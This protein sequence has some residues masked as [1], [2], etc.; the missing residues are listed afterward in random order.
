MFVR[1]LGTLEVSDG[2]PGS[3]S[4]PRAVPGAKERALLGRLLICPGRAVPVN[5]LIDD[6]WG[7]APP[8]SARKSLQAHVVRLRTSLEPERPRG[9]PGQ[10]VVHRGDG[11]LLAFSPKEVDAGLVGLSAASGRAALAA[12]QAPAA[13]TLFADALAYW[14]GEAFADWPDAP[15]AEGERR[16]LAGIREGLLEG[17]IDAD[18]ALGRHREL[19]PELEAMAAAEP[20]NEGWWRRLMLALYRSERQADALAAGR[21]ARARLDREL[22]VQP[23]PQLRQLEEEILR[24]SATLEPTAAARS[25]GAGTVAAGVVPASVAAETVAAGGVAASPEVSN[26]APADT[27]P[28]RGL[29]R[30]EA[31][32]ARL[33]FGRGPVIRGLVARVRSARLVVVSGPSGAGKSSLVRAG[34]LPELSRDVIP[35]SGSWRQMVITPGE[36]PV[37]RLAAAELTGDA[38]EPTVLV[39]DQFEELWTGPVSDGEREAFLAGLL[40]LLD[41]GPV[42]R[43]VLVVRGDHL[44]RLADMAELADATSSGLVLAPPMTE[45]E[46]REVVQGPAAVASLLVDPDLTETV[47]REV[48]GRAGVLPLLSSAL[49]GTWERRRGRSLTLSGYLECGGVTGALASVA[50]EAL[51]TLG[52]AEQDLAHR[53]LVRLAVPGDAGTVVRRSAPL[54]ELGVLPGQ[55]TD[56]SRTLEAFVAARLVTVDNDR[57]EVTHEAVFTAWPRLAAWL[58]EDAAGRAV[59]AHLAPAAAVW[60]A[61]GRPADQL[62]R[63]ARLEAAQEWIERPDSDPT[64]TEVAFVGASKA[65]SQAELAEAR[66]RVDAERAGRRRTR[67]LALVLGATAAVALLAGVLALNGQ[68]KAVAS[69]VLA[70]ADGLAAASLTAPS[71]DLS[72]L[73]AVQANR[74]ASTPQTRDTL[75]ASV[76]AHDHMQAVLQDDGIRQIAFGPDGHTLYGLDGRYVRAWDLAAPHRPPRRI[77]DL[78]NDLGVPASLAVSRTGTI[79]VIGPPET[80]G[81]G[82]TLWLIY[83]Y[84]S[85]QVVT[86]NALNAWPVS[87]RF[88]PTGAS[89]R[90]RYSRPDRQHAG[91]RGRPDR[92]RNR[93][94]HEHDHPHH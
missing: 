47:L 43:L 40:E 64:A 52:P 84:G 82:P 91:A 14:R 22:G 51:A 27:C 53:M 56:R 8:P 17:R 13:R 89:W 92:S 28:Y 70:D 63:G 45:S 26:G 77:I 20:L 93:T 3:G 67:N 90:W 76:V 94:E 23:G 39:V 29:A 59:R 80:G 88:T 10:F 18:L 55:A 71:P 60:E 78:K 9:S 83:P 86:S 46:V 21:R 68:R 49:A 54:A 33:L 85:T 4:T 72:M 15:W 30:Y 35:G 1:V 37:D 2:E 50:E 57:A 66:A 38:P 73:L 16:R 32:D 62:Y 19:L 7:G 48:S 44:G 81:T 25:G 58:V 61:E 41:N 11:Y 87:A 74:I 24:Q 65:R 69:S 75:L 36:R 6:L 34:L 31:S 12:G 5:T 42:Q 79:A